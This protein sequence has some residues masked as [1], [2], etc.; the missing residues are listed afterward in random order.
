M[1]S[2]ILEILTSYFRRQG[3][4]VHH[5][6]ICHSLGLAA[7]TQEIKPHHVVNFV[8]KAGLSAKFVK[9]PLHQ[10]HGLTLPILLVLNDGN[11]CLVT[12]L[13][14]NRA[15]GIFSDDLSRSLSKEE[16]EK[17]YSGYCFFLGKTPQERTESS[18]KVRDK[19]GW[20]IKAI[21]VSL[22][23]YRDILLAS[24]AINL[25]V[26]AVP[27]FTM[28]VYDRVVPNFATE[29]LWVLASA[30]IL[31]ICFDALLKFLRVNFIELATKKSDILI[32]SLLFEKVMDLR[33]EAS[34]RNVG[35]FA[36]NIRE[37]D[38][39]KNFMSS[40]VI[41]F[42]IDLPFALLFLAMI[43]YVGGPLVLLPMACMLL[44]LIY[45]LLIKRPLFASIAATF[46]GGVQKNALL[47]ESIAGLKTI[48]IF[49]AGG[50]FRSRW[51]NLVSTL[52]GYG[53]KTRFLSSSITTVMGMLIQLNSVFI[54]IY[55]VYLIHDG[56]LS[57]GGLI[58]VMIL[59]SRAIS[60]VGQVA[61]LLSSYDQ[62]KVAYSSLK[63]IMTLPAEL[64]QQQNFLRPE[65]LRGDICFKDVSL[66]YPEAEQPS[67]TRVSF[68]IQPGEKVALLGANGSGKTTLH[69]LM[70]GFYTPQEG[71]ILIDNIEISAISPILLR[72]HI[73][74]VPQDITLFAGTLRDN[75]TLKNVQIP[76]PDLLAAIQLAGL[77]P[78][79]A[80]C[81]QGLG[82]PISEAGSNLSGGQRQAVAIARAFTGKPS[83]ALLDEPSNFMDG[84]SEQAF[85]ERL[86]PIIQ[87]MTLIVSSHRNS[88]LSLVDRVIVVDQGKIV[89][90]GSKQNFITTFYGSAAR[91]KAVP[92]N[93]KETGQSTAATTTTATATETKKPKQRIVKKTITLT[94]GPTGAQQKKQVTTVKNTP[95]R[96]E[97]TSESTAT[98]ATKTPDR[99]TTTAVETRKIP[100]TKAV[101]ETAAQ[102]AQQP[103]PP[104]SPEMQPNE[105]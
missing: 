88:L 75:L 77:E 66:S 1:K 23:I 90:D 22:P 3:K 43:F 55:G 94:P 9:K 71:S 74:C 54:V 65:T 5:E 21:K 83:I 40:S 4:D 28:N 68:H 19:N 13:D 102:S 2:S 48:K 93:T 100:L 32:S 87:D 53:I 6:T 27:M 50:Q 39:I 31:I 8:K 63:N 16:L 45:V 86:R 73:A 97:N 18:Q 17:N 92:E 36:T 104:R 67:V 91:K 52:A 7:D 15:E 95:E 81:P 26:L 37:F 30:V 60:P 46:E 105:Q 84:K 34:P 51:E 82:M 20:F 44:L 38:S 80:G 58:A 70:L 96:P 101:A 69:R 61:S 57:M 12:K 11:G 103:A 85:V 89:F 35:G 49:N 24:L 98:T 47:I 41:L 99:K 14:E 79:I 29:T 56:E 42:V 72:Q 33:M 64:E 25:F 59:S 78:L 62:T 10:I 76:D